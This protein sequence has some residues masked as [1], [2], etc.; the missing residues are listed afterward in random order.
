MRRRVISLIVL[1]VTAAACSGE[2]RNLSLTYDGAGCEYE[3]P[4]EISS[5]Q[6]SLDFVNE[7]FQVAAANLVLIEEG[8]T[9][10]DLY[11]YGSPYPTVKHAP[12]WTRSISGVWRET[13]PGETHQWE[14]ELGAGSYA[15]ACFGL[16]P[17][18]A[19]YWGTGLTVTD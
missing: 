10:E 2:D 16:R 14:G 9:I 11:D 8:Y 13:S 15:M 4:T 19:G 1:I 18:Y 3:G 12:S 7:G 6:A 5:G 17:T